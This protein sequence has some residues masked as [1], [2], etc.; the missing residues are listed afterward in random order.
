MELTFSG[1][2]FEWRGPAPHHFV[3]VPDAQAAA[4]EAASALVTYGW[5]MVPV[6]VTLGSLTWQ[7]SLWP[8]D[9]LYIVPMKAAIRRELGLSLGDVV[10]LTLRLDV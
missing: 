8:K 6:E 3:Q 9:G 2:I 10:S 5:G 4:I 1:P 7:T